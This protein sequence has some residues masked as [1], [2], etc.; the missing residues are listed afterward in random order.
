MEGFTGTTGTPTGVQEGT[1]MP[2][3]IKNRKLHRKNKITS[4]RGKIASMAA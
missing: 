1:A 4:N 2:R 3:D